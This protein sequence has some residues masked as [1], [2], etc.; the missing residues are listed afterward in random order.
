FT[1]QIQTVNATGM[2][3]VMIHNPQ[4]IIV[5]PSGVFPSTVLSSTSGVVGSWLRSGGVLVWM[6]GPFGFFSPP[7]AVELDPATTNTS[8]AISS[9]QS[10]L[11]YRLTE[12][13]FTGVSRM[14]MVGTAFSLALDIEYSDTRVAPTTEL[15]NSIGGWTIGHL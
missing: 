10:I 15:I 3:E 1:G 12:P 2:L 5:V 14:A 4:S 7:K 6:G 9:Q 13:A 8:D 11:G